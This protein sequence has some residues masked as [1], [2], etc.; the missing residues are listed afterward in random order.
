MLETAERR[1]VAARKESVYVGLGVP[2]FVA[3]AGIADKPVVAEAFEVAVFDAEECHQG[4]CCRR[5][6]LAASV[7]CVSLLL[8]LYLHE[9]EFHLGVEEWFVCWCCQSSAY[10]CLMVMEWSATFATTT[11]LLSRSVIHPLER[12]W[13]GIYAQM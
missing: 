12:M 10:R 9:K 5:F 2:V 11:E 13:S 8:V 4:F 7:E 1:V 3:V 6:C